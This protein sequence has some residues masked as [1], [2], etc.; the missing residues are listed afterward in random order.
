M[1]HEHWGEIKG[2]TQQKEE[3]EKNKRKQRN[4]GR[5]KPFQNKTEYLSYRGIKKS[6][7]M[8]RIRKNQ[9][10]CELFKMD[11]KTVYILNIEIALVFVCLL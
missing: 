8:E 7:K 11:E 5:K 9:S 6:K 4:F 3:K 2:K 10:L 1:D